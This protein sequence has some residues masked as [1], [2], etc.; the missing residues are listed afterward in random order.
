MLI[1]AIYW[2]LLRNIYGGS[3]GVHPRWRPIVDVCANISL[4]PFTILLHGISNTFAWV[5]L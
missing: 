4:C 1:F 5:N 2:L 3:L